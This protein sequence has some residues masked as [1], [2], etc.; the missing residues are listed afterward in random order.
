MTKIICFSL[1]AFTVSS[2]AYSQM[3]WFEFEI[4]E[5]KYLGVFLDFY[6]E[7]AGR[8]IEGRLPKNQED[9]IAEQKKNIK[10]NIPKYVDYFFAK[11]QWDYFLTH[12]K[13]K[14]RKELF[15]NKIRSLTEK[16]ANL[17]GLKPDRSRSL[18]I[19]DQSTPELETVAFIQSTWQPGKNLSQKQLIFFNGT[20]VE[21]SYAKSSFSKQKKNK[22]QITEYKRVRFIK[23]LYINKDYIYSAPLI[24]LLA[25]QLG[26]TGNR[27][28]EFAVKDLLV[29]RAER[30]FYNDL[31]VL[32][33]FDELAVKQEKDGFHKIAVK[34]YKAE[35]VGL[36]IAS[37]E[38]YF[39]RQ[40]DIANSKVG[41]KLL[42]HLSQTKMHTYSYITAMPKRKL[43]RMKKF[44]QLF[45]SHL[46]QAC[47]GD[48][49]LGKMMLMRHGLIPF[50]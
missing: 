17:E 39:Q 45:A 42:E 4:K 12:I 23:N 32:E 8:L 20:Y 49:N 19:L 29:N 40:D 35:E 2:P 16:T 46:T 26:V 47:G 15:R 11:A 1:L 43:D 41:Q 44:D 48:L 10:R 5:K 7:P 38:A 24:Y 18:L 9:K 31:F 28:D 13:N 21:D 25:D 34:K 27:W 30:K 33:A 6:D 50:K 14:D 3:Q 22:E 36:Y 37:E